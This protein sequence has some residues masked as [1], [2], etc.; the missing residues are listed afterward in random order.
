MTLHAW[1]LEGNRQAL[2]GGAMFG[3][4]PKALWS[5]WVPADADN[6]IE[7]ACR[8]LLVDGING[9]LVLFEAGIGAFFEPK[10][11]E[12][13]GVRESEHVLLNAI[14]KI[15]LTPEDID[16]IV[17]SHLH[18]DH[19]GGLLHAWQPDQPARLA[20]PNARYV[21][22]AGH[23][24]RAR[25]PHPRDRASFIPELHALLEGTGRLELVDG[26]QSDCLGP[27]VRLHYSDGHTPGLMLSEIRGASERIVYCAD[28]IPGR[29]W[30]HLPVT[31]GYDRNAEL[32]INEKTEFLTQFGDDQTWLYFTHDIGC[33]AARAQRDA[34][35]NWAPT[36]PQASWQ[37]FEF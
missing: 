10:L 8:S 2:D 24:D 1:S 30:L 31:M 13:F 26:A 12:R 14:A 16:V 7:L 27:Q 21:V 5:R 23:W 35:G 22:S 6:R 37:D 33:A 29:A 19:A 34:R 9:Q 32:L 20:F 28:L 18:F 15:G 3:N 11:R 17:L 25:D 36:D 4:V